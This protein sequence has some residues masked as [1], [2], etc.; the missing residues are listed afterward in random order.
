[1]SRVRKQAK[2]VMGQANEKQWGVAFAMYAGDWDNSAP[3]GWWD[4]GQTPG[5]F[6]KDYWMEALRPYYGNEHDLRCCPMA[7]KSGTEAGGSMYGGNGTFI[8]WGT[9]PNL[10]DCGEPSSAWGPAT[11]C[12]YGSYGMNAWVCNPPPDAPVFQNHNV[13][14][15]NFR[16]FQVRGAARVPLLGDAQWIDCW[17]MQV[18][19]VPDG[20]GEPWG[21]TASFSHMVRVCINRHQNYVNWVFMDYSV[22]K[23]G[24][25]ELWKLYW[26]KGYRINDPSPTAWD[27]PGHWMFGMRDYD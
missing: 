14:L 6:N 15:N 10:D 5:P 11:A 18:D 16:T 2:A 17:P 9:F 12:D 19:V 25:K 8:G 20:D 1:M 27:T 7:M 22:R 21:S 3:R 24:L 26:H 4:G 13:A 23:V